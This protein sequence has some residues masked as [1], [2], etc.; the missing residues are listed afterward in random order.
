MKKHAKLILKI[1][2][3][4]GILGGNLIFA[5]FGTIF[6]ME[7]HIHSALRTP[8]LF[9]LPVFL[10]PLVWCKNREA[11]LKAAAAFLCIWC[12][13]MGINSEIYKYEQK[14]KV[15]MSPNINVYEYLPF[16]ED[17]K[18]VKLDSSMKLSGKLPRVDGA[19]AVFPVYSAFV[20]AVYP[21]YVEL[22]RGY[23]EDVF[24]YTNTVSGYE[25][26]AERR[27]D[28]FFGAYPSEDQ[29]AYAAELGTEFE[30]TQIG[31]EAFVFFVNV[32]NPVDNLTS[33]QVRDIYSGKITNWS[34]VGGKNKE[35]IAYQRNEGSGS[36]SMLER[37]MGDRVLMDAPT[38]RVEDWMMGIMNRV[39]EYRTKS[40]SLGFSFRYYVTEIVNNP[41]IKM[42]SIDGV[43]PTVENIK[44]GTYPII[45]GLYAVTYKDNENENVDKLLNWILGPEGQYIIEE[46][47][48]A[49]VD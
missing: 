30:F 40:N 27:I 9:I 34:Q 21:Y 28:I 5:L 32:D 18:I 20:N 36:Q 7:Q 2:L 38:E 11:I 49:G 48:Y 14:Q 22:Q 33:E 3:T 13:A 19:A 41:K 35:I 45:T 10:I 26:L 29:L 17:S 12:L 43:Y 23:P 1:L 6:L 8:V 4:L 42:L 46:T 15:D 24:N 47:G 39:A 25:R 44:N 16:T 31:S 37:F